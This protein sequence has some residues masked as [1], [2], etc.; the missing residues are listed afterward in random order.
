MKLVSA[1][2]VIALLTG[3]TLA[4]GVIDG[5]AQVQQNPCAKIADEFPDKTLTAIKNKLRKLNAPS[6]EEIESAAKAC[7]NQPV[8]FTKDGSTVTADQLK[9]V[10]EIVLDYSGDQ[11]N[12]ELGLKA[13]N[14]AVGLGML[15]LS[16]NKSDIQA[17][18]VDNGVV[19]VTHEEQT[20]LGLW[21]TTNTFFGE[22]FRY[23]WGAFVGT[24]LSGDDRLLNSFALGLSVASSRVNKASQRDKSGN[25]PL[26]FQLGWGWTR[27]QRLAGGYADGTPLPAGSSQPVLKKETAGGPVLLVSY[28]L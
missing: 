8:G 12:E 6:L 15:S 7:A 20:K 10:S 3:P 18:V 21:L 22:G 26:V 13:F 25:A 16:K 1:K 11:L 19:R 24:Q 4:L 17:A 27:V 9:S 23:R 14:F 2:W 5:Y 28:S